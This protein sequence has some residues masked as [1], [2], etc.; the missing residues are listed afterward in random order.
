MLPM[1][2]HAFRHV[3]Q[4][5]GK[6]TDPANSRFRSLDL[7][8]FDRQAAAQGLPVSWR[9]S[10][11]SREVLRQEF[12]SQHKNRDLWVFGYGSLMWDPCV[13]FDE[14]RIAQLPGYHRS[15]CLSAIT[16]RGTPD[17][18][19]LMAALD[20]GR[21]CEG[22]VFRIPGALVAEETKFIWRREMMSFGYHAAT[23]ELETTQ[24]PLEAV[25]FVANREGS[26]YMGDLDVDA[27]AKRIAF[28][29]GWSGS[30][31]EYAEKLA[32]QLELLG[33]HDGAFQDLFTKVMYL[34]A[35]A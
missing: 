19:G 16:G 27:A 21:S 18:P 35:N 33:L 5:R 24:G 23:L 31:F 8:D 28:A 3:P 26:R 20:E 17:H 32:I 11:E 29:K 7:S 4:L 10:D 2:E 9:R 12:L 30:S 14:V 25:T 6:I 13:Y 15:F 22:I 34:R 1:D